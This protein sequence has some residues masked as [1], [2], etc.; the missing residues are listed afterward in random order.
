[1]VAITPREYVAKLL[2]RSRAYARLGDLETSALHLYTAVTYSDKPTSCQA[3][4]Y[5]V[6]RC[7]ATL[8]RRYGLSTGKIIPTYPNA[9]IRS[10]IHPKQHGG[11]FPHLGYN[12]NT[13]TKGHIW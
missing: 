1:M 2:L 8:V 5:Q 7:V 10:R 3:T 9:P 4:A 11:E 6:M 13:Y 12:A